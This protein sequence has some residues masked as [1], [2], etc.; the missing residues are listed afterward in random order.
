MR[1]HHLAG[2]LALAWLTAC[3]TARAGVSTP[4]HTRPL[5]IVPARARMVDLVLRAA[6]RHGVPAPLAYAT[7][8]TESDFDPLARSS[9]G[10]LGLMQVR[11]GTA[12]DAGC[13]GSLLEPAANADCGVRILAALLR[14]NLGSWREAARHYNAGRWA[15][16]G[17][18]RRYAALVLTRARRITL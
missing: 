9:A 17:V 14:E 7:A 6:R 10:A 1:L 13:R 15:R 4:V 8:L 18:G 2:A 11:P 5:D 12:R 3:D 16:A